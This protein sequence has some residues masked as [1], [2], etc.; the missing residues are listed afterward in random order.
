MSRAVFDLQ[1]LGRTTP[2]GDVRWKPA[3]RRRVRGALLW[4]LRRGPAAPGAG[5][6]ARSC[7]PR[8]RR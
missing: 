4:G 5:R 6:P 1:I 8:L 7:A 2:D 3:G